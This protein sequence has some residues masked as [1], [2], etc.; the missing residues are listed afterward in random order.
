MRRLLAI[1]ACASLAGCFS[2]KYSNGAVRCQA[3]SHPCPDGYYCAVDNTC[4]K[5]GEGPNA[6]SDGGDV[7]MGANDMAQP[8]VLTYPAAAVW[9]S[10]GGGSSTAASGTELNFS[11]CPSL[12]GGTAVSPNGATATFGLFSNDTY[13]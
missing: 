1:V 5:N 13:Q 6:G 7:D 2:P 3:G 4:W 10:C 11:L 9:T 12:I 8:P